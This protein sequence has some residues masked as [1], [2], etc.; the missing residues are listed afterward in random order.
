MSQSRN[1]YSGRGSSRNDFEN[2]NWELV[3]RYQWE[4]GD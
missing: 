1:G 2:D 4:A 3:G